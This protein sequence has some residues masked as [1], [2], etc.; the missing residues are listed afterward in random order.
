[1]NK[2]EREVY[3][4]REQQ[5]ANRRKSNLLVA[6]LVLLIL[7]LSSGLG[8]LTFDSVLIGII[9]GVVATAVVV[10]GQFM[11]SKAVITKVVKGQ[12]VETD[13][14][15]ERM[16]KI[17]SQLEG[18]TIAA[19]LR[20]TPDLYLIPTDVANA[21]AGGMDERTAYIGVTQGLVD[22]MDDEEMEGVLA[23]EMAHVMNLDVRLNTVVLSLVTVIAVLSEMM[24]RASLGGDSKS[25]DSETAGG[26]ALFII[27]ASM[28]LAPF[29]RLIGNLIFLG[30]SRKREFLADA[31]AV[32]LCGYN[33]GLIR[34]LQKLSGRTK[35][36]TKEERKS[37][38]GDTMMAMYFNHPGEKMESKFS[39]HPPIEERINILEKIY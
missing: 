32:R 31:T 36:Y 7:V 22:M 25:S 19:G 15:D 1:M 16:L 34:A 5:I 3:L 35:A 18:L 12:K 24:F 10:P 4:V 27:L 23:H 14:E 6:S 33:E 11:L 29:A 2:G 39:T 26:I 38:G 17:R 20:R 8:V 30:V 21:F 9:I 28:I 37:L 13:I